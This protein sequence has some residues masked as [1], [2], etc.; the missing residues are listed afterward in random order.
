MTNNSLQRDGWCSA[1]VP[2]LVHGPVLV[3]RPV[4][5]AQKAREA[6]NLRAAVDAHLTNGGMY[7][8]IGTTTVHK[9]K[10]EP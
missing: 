7:E 9:R 2:R 3:D 5:P 8:F 1:Q 10:E 4:H 6:D